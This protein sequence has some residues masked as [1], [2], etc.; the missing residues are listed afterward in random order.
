MN[1]QERYRRP[2]HVVAHG[3]GGDLL[4]VPTVGKVADLRGIFVLN[5][6]GATVWEY[7]AEARTADALVDH[8]CESFEV[9]PTQAKHDVGELLDLLVQQHLLYIEPHIEPPPSGGNPS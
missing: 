5:E 1:P 7:L 2:D 9:E 4:L 6:T 3:V 8:V